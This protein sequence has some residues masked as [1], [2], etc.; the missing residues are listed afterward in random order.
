M[1]KIF[2]MDHRETKTNSFFEAVGSTQESPCV[3]YVNDLV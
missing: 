3:A 2:R 1:C